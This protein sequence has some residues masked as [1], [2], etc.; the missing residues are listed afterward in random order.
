MGVENRRISGIEPGTPPL[1]T[2]SRIAPQSPLNAPDDYL[3]LASLPAD[4]ASRASQTLQRGLDI[5]ELVAHGGPT[6]LREIGESIKLT[7][8]TAHRLTL[9]LSD[10]GLL[11]HT[12]HGYQLG[13]KLLA[14]AEAAR[15]N[16]PLTTLARPHLEALAQD[17]LD[18]VNLAIRDRDQVRY[19]DQVRGARR[20][21]VGSIV[22]EM[23]P[24]ATTALGRA[25]LLDDDESAWRKAHETDQAAPRGQNALAAWLERMRLF[26]QMGA[27]FDVEENEDRVRCVA[28]PVRDASGQIVAAIS[29]SSLPQYLDDN[30]MTKLVEPVTQTA[31]AIASELGWSGRRSRK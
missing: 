18:A 28:A 10:R 1:P 19:L 12:R 7:R 6:G 21:V 20:M 26:R 5:L 13:P 25:L 14:L 4:E 30:R 11:R 3:E 15:L 31:N 22:G 24:M 8:S 29:L 16:R 27:A 23:R 2:P 17:Q 9:A